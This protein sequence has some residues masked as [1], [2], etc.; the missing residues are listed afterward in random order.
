[1]LKYSVS[2]ILITFA[3]TS[4][5]SCSRSEPPSPQDESVARAAGD[6][7]IAL[8]GGPPPFNCHDLEALIPKNGSVE[9]KVCS[10]NKTVVNGWSEKCVATGQCNTPARLRELNGAAEAFC[11][12]WCAKK[13]CDYRY[14]ARPKCDSSWCQ[15]SR[16]CQQNCDLPLL[17]TCYFQ[18]PAPNYNCQCIEK[19]TG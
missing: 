12:D 6:R 2:L 9:G 11:A 19:V 4:A 10:Q 16:E 8:Q 17:D 1:M 5:T 18:Q 3:L 13:Q 7:N 14:T 15:N